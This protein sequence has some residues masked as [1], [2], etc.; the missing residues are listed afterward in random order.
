MTAG[1]NGT[2]VLASAFDGASATVT[3]TPTT[4][5]SA[6]TTTESSTTTS[7]PSTT[8]TTATTSK[9]LQLLPR[10]RPPLSPPPPPP[11]QLLQPL[12]LLALRRQPYLSCHLA[13]KHVSV[14]CWRNTRLLAAAPP[15]QPVSVG[16]S[17]L[18]M[19]SVTAPM[20]LVVLLSLVQLFLLKA[21]LVRLQ[22]QLIKSRGDGSR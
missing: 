15:T 18:A 6:I 2:L 16:M 19:V 10:H 14:T 1:V 7:Q 12:P 13:D 8:T 20:V 3:G 5:T 9:T 4:S 22:L 17:T 21:H 11:H